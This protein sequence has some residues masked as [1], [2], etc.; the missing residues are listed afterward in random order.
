MSAPLG[1]RLHIATEDRE[2]AVAAMPHHIG[3][4]RPASAEVLIQPER[5]ECAPNRLGLSCAVC[6][7][8]LVTVAATTGWMRP[9]TRPY[10]SIG[11]KSVPRRRRRSG[12]PTVA[13]ALRTG[14]DRAQAQ[15]GPL[16]DL[17][18]R[19]GADRGDHPIRPQVTHDAVF[20]VD[21]IENRGALGQGVVGL[22]SARRATAR[23]RPSAR[24]TVRDRSS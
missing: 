6:A 7:N 13:S 22:S 19:V 17:R 10:R 14:S 24:C 4:L 12:S 5:S 11:R 15:G 3:S 16:H 2:G 20:P 8:A 18:D 1:G 9:S 23:A 21:R